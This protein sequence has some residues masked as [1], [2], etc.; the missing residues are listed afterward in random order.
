MGGLLLAK[1]ASTP[2]LGLPFERSCAERF[3]LARDEVFLTNPTRPL[4]TMNT[5]ELEQSIEEERP[6]STAKQFFSGNYW[7]ISALDGNYTQQDSGKLTLF[8]TRYVRVWKAG[9]NQIRALEEDLAKELGI[10]DYQE[11]VGLRKKEFQTEN[12]IEPCIY[13]VIRDPIQHFLSGYNEIEFRTFRTHTWPEA[14]YHTDLPYNKT[15]DHKKRFRA[16]V[17]DLLVEDGSFLVNSVYSH[18]FSMSRVLSSLAKIGRQLNGY[19][20][21]LADLTQRW[22]E[23]LTNTCPGLP[24]L[25]NPF[26]NQRWMASTSH[27]KIPGV[28]TKLP[29]RSGRRVVRLPGPCAFCRPQTMPVSR[30]YRKEF[31]NFA[32]PCTGTTPKPL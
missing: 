17:E 30:I 25:E 24:P 21:D 31:P 19:L 32:R 6:T 1:T 27:R 11:E 12:G 22:P 15:D 26:P 14:P 23:F 28:P 18:C 10:S 4:E 9:N 16:F 8:K 2:L 13:T 29:R 7:G 5:S 20:T 3:K